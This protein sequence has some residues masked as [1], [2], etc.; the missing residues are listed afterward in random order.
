MKGK[1]LEAVREVWRRL[2]PEGQG[3][4][5]VE[6][7]MSAFNARLLPAVRYDGVSIDTARREY[8][9]GLGVCS[10]TVES[11]DAAFALEEASE[12]RRPMPVGAPA[13]D[14]RVPR[15][16]RNQGAGAALVASA[17]K[18]GLSEPSRGIRKQA[19]PRSHGD[20]LNEMMTRPSRVLLNSVITATQF[21]D[22]YTALSHGMT[23]D[24]LF[25]QTLRD[26]WR[27]QERHHASVVGRFDLSPRKK[28][29]KQ[30]L[31]RISANFKDGSQRV[32]NLQNVDGISEL[33]GHAGVHCSQIWTWGPEV[34]AEII[35]RL[36]AE[37]VP[38]VIQIKP[39]PM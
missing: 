14:V 38:G 21:E 11:K 4:V 8:L 17:G 28:E 12:C 3:Y 13:P 10:F 34:K 15:H 7:F 30:P 18:E 33:L 31:F 24:G 23:D 9:E 26:P 1:H 20:F 32:V 39:H 22:Y 19:V 37:G 35:R 5:K 29:T 25:E 16:A 27:T 6:H 2:D 36:E